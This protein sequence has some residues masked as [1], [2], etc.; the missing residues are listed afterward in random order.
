MPPLFNNKESKLVFK[1]SEKTILIFYRFHQAH[2]ILCSSMTSNLGSKQPSFLFAK[3][4]RKCIKPCDTD[5]IQLISQFFKYE[6]VEQPF[7][8][9]GVRI[10]DTPTAA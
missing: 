6:V 7:G 4:P 2:F 5:I 10:V 8:C 1:G 3:V 9:Y